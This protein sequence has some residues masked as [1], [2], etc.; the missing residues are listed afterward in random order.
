MT[1]A[2]QGPD[3]TPAGA[4]PGTE[5][6][7]EPSLLVSALPLLLLIVALS[8]NVF[9]FGDDAVSGSNQLILIGAAAI[10][11]LLAIG[12]GRSWDR[13]QNGILDAIRLATP[14]ILILLLVGALSGTWLISGIIPAMIYYGLQILSPE[15]FLP[16]A[17]II[18]ACVA[19]FTGSSWTSVA[20]IGIALVGIGQVLGQNEAAVAG[21]IISGAYFG[22]KLSPLSD[23][24]NLASAASNTELFSH[25]RYMALTT[26]P[27]ITIAIVIFAL[28]SSDSAN[29]GATQR[30]EEISEVLRTTI[31]LTPWLFVPP[32]IIV[33]LILKKVPALPAILSGVLLGALLA[34]I[35]QADLLEQ[36]TDGSSYVSLMTV[37][38]GDSAIVTGDATLDELL[39]AGGMQGMLSTIWLVLAAM[40]FGGVM[41]A[42]GFL[43]RIT[44]Y[45]V[46]RAQ[47]DLGLVS[48]TAGTCVFTNVTASDQYLAVIV[49]GR[50]FANAYEER[51]LAPQN[52]SRTLE[53]AGTVTS[54][55]IP[56]NTCGAFHAGV[57]GVS[58]LAYAP[59]AIFCYLSPIMTL[60]FMAFGI[61]IARI[62]AT[63]DTDLVPTNLTTN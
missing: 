27:S 45:L 39:T 18:T 21:A 51:G 17:C 32:L 37:M 62:S 13:L 20:T 33:G 61:G 16:G 8:Y 40:C 9:V 49:P 63:T 19:L 55:L 56:W 22:D 41:E 12:Q 44:S 14:A 36:I 15:I 50:M 35:V 25:V 28:I 24:T 38:Y 29:S 30:T 1:Q 3:G 59:F 10:A 7:A 53:D 54:P 23:T 58:T 26:V 60:A 42:S 52:L 34:P 6:A 47:T 46:K 11:A 4:L 48:A 43:R 2:P 31:N 57:L 5:E